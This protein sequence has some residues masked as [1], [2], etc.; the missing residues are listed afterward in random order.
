MRQRTSA[1]PA[2]PSAIDFADG[3]AIDPAGQEEHQR[4]EAK[5][6]ALGETCCWYI[7]GRNM[8]SISIVWVL[9]KEF[10]FYNY[11]RR[12]MQK[13]ATFLFHQPFALLD[14]IPSAP[15]LR[16]I[17]SLSSRCS[18]P[19]T[20]EI[21]LRNLA[22]QKPTRHVQLVTRLRLRIQTSGRAA[23][24][25]AV[26]RSEGADGGKPS[27]LGGGGQSRASSRPIRH[28]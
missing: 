18:N 4:G 16:G 12:P 27:I 15:P 13:P 3:S 2:Q 11:R 25:R 19:L 17:T 14:S 5:R 22:A 26:G 20:R 1:R 6:S 24:P 7:I 23:G 10:L 28:E 8:H 21:S 9:R